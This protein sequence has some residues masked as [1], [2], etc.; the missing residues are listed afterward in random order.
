M[1][2]IIAVANQKGGVGK[3]TTSINLSSSL[4]YYNK[5]VLMVDLDPQGSATTGLG[6]SRSELN[7]SMY[8]VFIDK[9]KISD[10]VV[11]PKYAE[12]DVAPTTVDLAS[13]E[14]KI[15]NDDFRYYILD[16]LIEQERKNYDYIIID[17]PPSLGL[18]TLNALYTADSVIIPVQCQFFAV[19]GLT[20]LINTIRIVQKQKKVNGKKLEIEGI[21]FTMLDKRTKA[22]WEVVHEVKDYFRNSVFD[23]IITSNV[24]AQ[25]APRYGMPVMKYDSRSASAVLYKNLAKEILKKN[26][27]QIR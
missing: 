24:S 20:Q 15:V 11:K 22:G 25:I 3:T 16:N 2:K 12:F 13:V 8:N 10:I 1:A 17:C 4:Q 6:I 23:T 9:M 5:R 14:L 19:D 27:E 18:L 26:G 21:L 7:Y